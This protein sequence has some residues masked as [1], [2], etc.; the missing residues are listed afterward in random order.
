MRTDYIATCAAQL[1]RSFANFAG[2]KI[3]LPNYFE[4]VYP[5]EVTQKDKRSAKEI[6][7]DILDKL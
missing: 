3:D 4:M 2:G 6:I 1:L 5:G 7:K